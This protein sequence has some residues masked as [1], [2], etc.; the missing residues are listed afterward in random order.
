MQGLG[1][2]WQRVLDTSK[3]QLLLKF[4]EPLLR[5][6]GNHTQWQQQLKTYSEEQSNSFYRANEIEV[7]SNFILSQRGRSSLQLV[8]K[9]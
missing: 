1:W 6:I 3:A 4:K 5:K 2:T 9:M 8:E 7:T